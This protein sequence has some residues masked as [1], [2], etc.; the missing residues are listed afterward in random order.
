MVCFPVSLSF[1][2]GSSYRSFDYPKERKYQEIFSK[3]I[4]AA[5]GFEKSTSFT[6]QTRC[7]PPCK[8]NMTRQLLD[9]WGM[10]QQDLQEDAWFR[11][12]G[13]ETAQQDYLACLLQ[14]YKQACEDLQPSAKACLYVEEQD[15]I[16]DR[17]CHLNAVMQE[18]EIFFE[19]CSPRAKA[20]QSVFYLSVAII[21]AGVFSA[22]IIQAVGIVCTATALV[23]ILSACSL[24]CLR[25][26][27]VLYERDIAHA[28]AQWERRRRQWKTLEKYFAL[29]WWKEIISALGKEQLKGSI[30]AK[31]RDTTIRAVRRYPQKMRFTWV[32]SKRRRSG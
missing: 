3:Q 25:L 29:F 11:Q 5:T 2:N 26:V 13:L 20:Q 23:S 4:T 32:R 19:D 28:H 15:A 14:E 6:N 17:L 30:K 1:C 24:A 8:R 12:S 18:I 10:V 21:V 9:Q 16:L 22:V 31:Q 27:Y 7:K